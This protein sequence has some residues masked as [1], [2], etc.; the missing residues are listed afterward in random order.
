MW[1]A[2]RAICVFIKKGSA[3]VDV[4]I[5]AR[6]VDTARADLALQD[7]QQAQ[8]GLRTQ[9]RRLEDRIAQLRPAYL[10]LSAGCLREQGSRQ[11]S[12]LLNALMPRL[13]RPS[14]NTGCSPLDTRLV[15]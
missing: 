2:A 15:E 9:I 7:L 8:D 1:N 4:A 10:S 11:N 6:L 12:A 13:S 14:L 3:D 5:L